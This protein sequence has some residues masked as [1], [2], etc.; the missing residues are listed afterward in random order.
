MYDVVFMQPAIY[1]IIRLSPPA[2]VG[3]GRVVPLPYTLF[4]FIQHRDSP[5]ESFFLP[6]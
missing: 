6:H 2:L 1:T 4:F 3:P 5:A